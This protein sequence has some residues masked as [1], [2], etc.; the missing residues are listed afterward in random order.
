MEPTESQETSEWR[1]VEYG[2]VKS[3]S[4]T[5]DGLADAQRFFNMTN[6]R[7]RLERLD[8]YPDAT[9]ARYVRMRVAQLRDILL[10]YLDPT[11]RRG[12]DPELVEETR[13][14]LRPESYFVHSYLHQKEEVRI[15]EE[16]L[17]ELPPPQEIDREAL[18]GLAEGIKKTLSDV[19]LQYVGLKERTLSVINAAAIQA[20]L[21]PDKATLEAGNSQIYNPFWGAS[22]SLELAD[23]A[24]RRTE[25]LIN[26]VDSLQVQGSTLESEESAF[27]QLH[28]MN[29]TMQAGLRASIKNLE[30][31]I[32]DME[33]RC[34]EIRL[35]AIKG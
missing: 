18:E 29:T 16:I 23:E 31:Q 22:A 10:D 33:T 32:S 9:Q 15:C 17:A 28:A 35:K 1:M 26:A 5:G 2:D 14:D 4:V 12:Y 6:R 25:S 24:V 19:R 30:S 13:G 20:E 21:S 27:A 11:S 34:G 8:T 7:D 3:F